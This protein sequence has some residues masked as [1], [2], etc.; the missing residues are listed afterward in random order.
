VFLRRCFVVAAWLGALLPACREP[1]FGQKDAITADQ[2]VANYVQAIGGSDRIAAITT[3]T[4]KGE[5]SGNLTSFAHPFSPPNLQKEKGNF[6]FYFKAPNLRSYLL[7]GENN[8]VMTMRGCDGTISW[9]VGADAVRRDFKPKPGSEYECKK[10]YDPMPM[11]VRAPDMHLQLKGKKKVGDRMA[12]V[13]RAQDPKSV[14][15]D[16]Y[17]FDVETF[18]LLRWETSVPAQFTIER[19]YSDYRDVGGM[20]LA[21]MVVQRGDN[22]SLTSILREVE[23][24]API[25]DARLQ[26][27]K[28]VGTHEKPE[29]FLESPAK[30]PEVHAESPPAVQANKIETAPL[31]T[32]S[33]TRPAPVSQYSVSSNFVSSSI[34]ELQQIV[35]ELR[36]LKTTEGQQPLSPLLDKIGERTVDLSRKIPNLISREEIVETQRGVK[37]RR[38][39]FSYLIL[40]RRSKDAVTLEEFRVDLKTGAML[41]TDDPGPPNESGS[42]SPWDDL[43]RASQRINARATGGPPLGQGFASMWLRFYPSNRS[44]SDFRYL[45]EQRMDGHHTLVVA[46]A[47]KPG[48]V[49]LPAEVRLEDKSLPVYYQGIAWVDAS[50]FRIVR[51]RTDLLSPITDLLLTQLTSE[52]RFADTQA[53]GF[54]SHLWLPREVVVTSQINRLTFHDKHN[55]SNYRSFQSHA[56]ILLNP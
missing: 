19:S 8:T 54:A 46:F 9:Y 33:E 3:F 25:D 41:E 26:A 20:K 22:S 1:A 50:D 5:L 6:Q 40:A 2:V 34:A 27:P 31:A 37:T 42:S 43:E 21:F 28:I 7:Y 10:G 48:S 15:T 44:E 55:Y 14:A 29:V 13:I 56:R 52:V 12:W 11:G 47:Q 17:F 49:R 24:N 38:E 36:E 32:L 23:I 18:L 4:E 51:L 45:G 39:D 53:T 16:I 35:P 30:R